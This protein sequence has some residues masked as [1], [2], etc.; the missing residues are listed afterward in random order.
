MTSAHALYDTRIFIKECRTLR[1]AGY[2]VTLIVQHDKDE[3]IE[4]IFIKGI[5]KPKNRRERMLK[6]TRQVYQRALECDAEIYHFHDPELIPVALRLKRRGKKVIYDAHE[7][8]PRQILSKQWIPIQLRKTFSWMIE[9]IENYSAKRFDYIIT[10]TALLRDRFLKVNERTQD[11]NNYPVLSEFHM[12]NADWNSKEKSVCYIGGIGELRGIYEMVDAI[13]MTEYNLLLAGSFESATERDI[14]VKKNGWSRVNELGY[15]NR[16]GVKEVFSRSM[17]GMVIIYPEP[18]YIN[19]QPTKMFEYMSAGLPTI[20]SCFPLWKQIV[21]GNNCG[22]CV[23]PFDVNEISNAINWIMD[24]PEQAKR[25]GENGR[26]AVEEKYNWEREGI[27]LF[28]IY[29]GLLQ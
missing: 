5:D 23:N 19:A 18:N 13:G 14:A 22:I 6:S 27:K 8:V 29:E 10:A 4:G 21:E 11:I 16:D 7:D 20:A 15:L 12:P 28:K 25:M 1:D 9:R 26:R 2:N 3:I 17:V 24:N